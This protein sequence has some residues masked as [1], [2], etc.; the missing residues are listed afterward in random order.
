M[1]QFHS[2]PPIEP[3]RYA[4]ALLRTPP[5]GSIQLLV[6][7]DNLLG[8]WTHF[9]AGRTVPCTGPACEACLAG[10]SS[11]WH[12]YLSAIQGKTRE[13]VLFELTALAAESFAAYR[14]KHQT[15]RGCHVTASRVNARPNARVHLVLKPHDLSG[16]DLP[17]AANL[18]AVLCHLW[19][20]PTNETEI[21][22]DAGQPPEI[23]HHGTQPPIDRGTSRIGIAPSTRDP[24]GNGS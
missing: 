2:Q 12:G 8:C 11:R 6:T 18:T 13:H 3:T 5:K 20:I 23:H 22:G 10:A 24:G 15:L 4:M 21:A 16:V 7:S 14:M 1:L 19:G 9:Y 17:P